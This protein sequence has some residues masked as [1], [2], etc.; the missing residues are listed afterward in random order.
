M[1]GLKNLAGCG[2]PLIGF[3]II[4]GL[5]LIGSAVRIVIM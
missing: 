2:V 5:S 4:V 1:E 3:L